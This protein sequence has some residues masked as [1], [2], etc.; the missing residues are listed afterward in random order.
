MNFGGNRH[1]QVRNWFCKL[2]IEL[3]RSRENDELT[4]DLL[5]VDQIYLL[6]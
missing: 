5:T 6:G 3:S 1:F 2:K 4:V